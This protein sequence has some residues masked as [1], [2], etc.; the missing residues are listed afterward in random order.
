[1]ISNAPQNT[2]ED[3]QNVTVEQLEMLH[4]IL[5]QFAGTLQEIKPLR[6]DCSPALKEREKKK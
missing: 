3:S 4:G 5:R 6:A 2:K 1:M